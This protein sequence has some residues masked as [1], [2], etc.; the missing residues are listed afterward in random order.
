[1]VSPYPVSFNVA[2]ICVAL[3]TNRFY[4]IRDSRTYIVEAVREV[5]FPYFRRVFVSQWGFAKEEDVWPRGAEERILWYC[6]AVN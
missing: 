2:F 6:F 1:M 3:P 5:I 4:R